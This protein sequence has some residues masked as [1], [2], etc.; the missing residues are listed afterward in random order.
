[1]KCT[2]KVSIIGCGSVGATAAYAMLL[3]GTPTDLALIDLSKERARGLMT[4]LEHALSFTEY[5]ALSAGDDMKLCE[6]SSVVFV[7]A[8]AR[9]KEGQTRLDLIETNRKIFKKIIPEIAK[10][11][12]NAIL[13]IVSNPVDILTYDAI[14]LSKFPKGR[15]F[16]S[17]T[18]LDTIRFQFHLGEKW[19]VN[20]QSIEAYILG[21]H[22]DT[23]F[24]VFSA[25]EIAGKPLVKF[26]GHSQ[27]DLEKAYKTTREAA[28][29]I[30]HDLGY[31]CYSI[32]VVMREI[33]KNIYDNSRMVVPLSTMLKGE[34]GQK[35]VCLSV[36]CVLGQN[37]I[38]RTIEIPL[39]AKEKKQLKKSADTLRK[40]Y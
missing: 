32:G 38:E 19:G 26:K 14:K 40:F 1:M 7:T 13:V 10:A 29:R 36:P 37:G 28:Y 30:I 33:M 5:T 8:G 3:D 27:K 23:S 9:Q 16:G 2:F 24:P 21:E 35:K 15:V 39:N 4:D 20:P 12:P 11:A 6:G 34:Y 31:T 17:G 22:G 25:A 18:M